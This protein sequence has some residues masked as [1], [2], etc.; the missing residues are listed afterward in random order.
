MTHPLPARP[1]FLL[2]CSQMLPQERKDRQP[3]ANG[4][5]SCS[6]SPW[7]VAG[8]SRRGAVRP[9]GPGQGE[10]GAGGLS[11]QGRAG[12]RPRPCVAPWVSPLQHHFPVFLINSLPHFSL[13][14]E[15][16][17]LLWKPGRRLE[18]KSLWE[19]RR[20]T[21]KSRSTSLHTGK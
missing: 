10:G 7:E 8:D 18:P 3:R 12:P 20:M 21:N 19:R 2:V 4:R 14:E 5:R 6:W 16:M 17:P 11:P 15:K 1:G 13:L 9:Q